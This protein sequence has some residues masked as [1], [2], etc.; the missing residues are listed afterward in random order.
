MAALHADPRVMATLG[1]PLGRAASDALVARMEASFSKHGFGLYC[2]EVKDGPACIGFV[3]LAVPGFEAAFTPCVEI[4]WRIA[5]E[6]WG[7]G[8]APEAGEAVLR[9]A[10]LDL[11]LDEVVSFTAVTNSNSIR[12]MEKL[13]LRHDPGADF[14]HPGVPEGS[15]LRRHR[16]HRLS[17]SAWYERRRGAPE[18][19]KA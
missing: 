13:G 11:G 12:V 4:G 7:R 9:H 16:L 3:G 10:F 1:A 6:Q 14:D 19:G 5:R 18:P 17:A 15:P 8:F 2:V